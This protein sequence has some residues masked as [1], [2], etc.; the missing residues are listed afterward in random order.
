MLNLDVYA[1]VAREYLAMKK[2]PQI[3]GKS[4]AEMEDRE[5]VGQLGWLIRK[6][7]LCEDYNAFEESKLGSMESRQILRIDTDKT[8]QYYADEDT[9]E[10]CQCAPCVNYR[11]RIA[12]AYP[13][14]AAYM[15][16]L[17]IDITKPY[18]LTYLKPV[19][20]VL[21]YDGCWYVAFGDGDY[22]WQKEF[23]DVKTFPA[24]RFPDPGVVEE[25]FVVLEIPQ[26]DLPFTK[27]DAQ[28]DEKAWF[29]GPP[30]LL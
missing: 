5:V 8:R 27:E 11:A 29:D 25:P 26:I 14:I 10:Y 9:A 4:I 2:I 18:E 12:S 16:T 17:G 13:E 1:K 3:Q 15:D 28:R 22:A 24:L 30:I 19:D 20:D 7:G 6:E 23:G 21:T